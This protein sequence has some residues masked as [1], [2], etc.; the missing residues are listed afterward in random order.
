MAM[1]TPLLSESA[2]STRQS[3]LWRAASR[4]SSASAQSRTSLSLIISACFSSMAACRCSP[5]SRAIKTPERSS[6][7]R[8][9][10]TK[11]LPSDAIEA[12]VIS[13]MRIAPV[14]LAHRSASSAARSWTHFSSFSCRKRNVSGNPSSR[15]LARGNC[16]RTSRRGIPNGGYV[17]V[18][19]MRGMWVREC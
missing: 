7:S 3:S 10:V 19:S 17:R 5:V 14:S 1:H 16:G 2:P 8:S 4:R 6:S 13:R 15:R 18:R 9:D 12:E 11:R